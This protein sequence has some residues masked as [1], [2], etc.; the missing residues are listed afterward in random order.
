MSMRAYNICALLEFYTMQDIFN[1]VE[2]GYSFLSLPRCGLKTATELGNL[3]ETFAGDHPADI[4]LNSFPPNV[5]RTIVSVFNNFSYDSNDL[6]SIFVK[7]YPSAAIFFNTFMNHPTTFVSRPTM[8]TRS[9]ESAYAVLMMAVRLARLITERLS[10]LE[11]AEAVL[12]VPGLIDEIN[13]KVETIKDLVS[14]RYYRVETL[15]SLSDTKKKMLERFYDQLRIASPTIVAN[16]AK[17]YFPR[18]EDAIGITRLD[19][20]DFMRRHGTKKKSATGYFNDVLTPFAK[21][22]RQ[23]IMTQ[24]DDCTITHV[25]FP[26]LTE[27]AVEFAARFRRTIGYY[28]L[29]HIIYDY[30]ANAESRDV[31]IF[32][33]KHGITEDGQKYDFDQIGRRFDLTRERVRQIVAQPNFLKEIESYIS[34]YLNKRVYSL[35]WLLACFPNSEWF[36]ELSEQENFPANFEMFADI[37][38]Y[39]YPFIKVE[40]KT[41]TYIVHPQYASNVETLLRYLEKVLGSKR[42][43]DIIVDIDT[44]LND[45]IGDL[46]RTSRR[47]LRRILIETIAPALDIGSNGY[48]LIFKKNTCDVEEETARILEVKGE[49]VHISEIIRQLREEN[50]RLS[51]KDA[52]IKFILQ[53]SDLVRPIGKSSYYSLSKWD[54]ISTDSI[55]DIIRKTLQ[56]SDK[57]IPIAQLN[58]RVLADYPWTTP[59]NIYANLSISPEFV[60]FQ[61][62]LFGL[63]SKTY[64]ESYKVSAGLKVH[65]SFKSRFERLKKFVDNYNRMPCQTGKECEASLSRWVDNCLT[66]KINIQPSQLAELRSFIESHAD[67]PQNGRE[68]IFKANCDKL[69]AYVKRH[70]AI[71][72]YRFEPS[73]YTWYIKNFGSYTA[74]KDNRRKYFTELLAELKKHNLLG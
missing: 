32:R 2:E 35:N 16:Y 22:L 25:E 40:R 4:F 6:K 37:Y 24:E 55:R 18:F 3:V 73:L 68:K 71:P 50:P 7:S 57:P 1:F 46:T 51:L 8:Y 20:E 47:D 65:Y 5:S 45:L 14:K 43:S 21:Y 42:P 11:E 61:G 38:C 31:R 10:T 74:Y 48:S 56:N 12:I 69:L 34:P 13:N 36:I 63:A 72:S 39:Y 70:G 29:F 52:T 44:L 28:P 64:D 26:F 17:F 67:I 60:M 49:P 30:I 58:Q 19:F 59:K 23:V 33:L 54:N 9:D 62:G 15:R 27:S 41:H 66:A 53:H